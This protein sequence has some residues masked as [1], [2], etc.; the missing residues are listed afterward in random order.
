[1]RPSCALASNI[2]CVRSSASVGSQ[3]DTRVAASI[4][5][6]GQPGTGAHHW[7][8]WLSL[9]PLDGFMSSS[10]ENLGCFPRSRSTPVT[11]AQSVCACSRSRGGFQ[12]S[13][14]ARATRSPS[15]EQSTKNFAAIA[16]RPDLSSTTTRATCPGRSTSAATK[17]APKKV[18]TPLACTIQSSSSWSA[19]GLKKQW[20]DSERPFLASCRV[21]SPFAARRSITCWV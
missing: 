6:S 16:R 20:T 5:A 2:P 13:K 8:T 17:L 18:R 9:A 4:V 1:M 19:A 15:P 7:K 10:K 11:S 21:A 14:P 12:V 3:A